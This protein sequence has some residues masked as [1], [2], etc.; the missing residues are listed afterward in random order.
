VASPR[1]TSH[2][3]SRIRG[4]RPAEPS[5]TPLPEAEDVADPAR[6]RAVVDHGLTRRAV[7]AGIRGGDALARE[8][9]CDADPYLLRAARHHGEATERPCPI[10]R[11]ELVHVTYVFGDELGPFSGRVKSSAELPVMA[12]EHGQF[13]VYV[14]EVCTDCGW[15]HLTMSYVLGDGVPR[16]PL[17][18]PPDLLD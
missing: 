16:R 8:D 7:L 13:R 9:H 6:P 14:V 15:N 12:Y 17:R 5:R 10:C 3:A 4:A 1:H 11:A 2:R 18:R